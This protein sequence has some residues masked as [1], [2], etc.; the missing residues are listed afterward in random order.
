MRHTGQTLSEIEARMERDTFMSAEQAKEFG[1][2]DEVC[3][4][5]P[6]GA[7]LSPGSGSRELRSCKVFTES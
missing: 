6:A 5:H 4:K 1:I 7:R 3:P 2:V